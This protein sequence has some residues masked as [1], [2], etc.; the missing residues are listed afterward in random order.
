[1]L[2][3]IHNVDIR[4]LQIF[5]TIVQCNGFSAAQAQLNMSQSAISTCMSSLETRLGFRLC[6]RGKK[7]FS[8]TAEGEQVLC[9][10]QQLFAKLDA[11]VLQVH[12]LSGRLRGELLIG[13]LDST[14]TLPEAKIVEAIRRFYQRNHEVSLQVFIKSPTELEQEIISGELHAAI[15]YIGH[16]LENLE[17]ID[18]FSEKISIYCGRHHPLYLSSKVTSGDL[19]RFSW[20]KR[21]YL[22]PSDLVPVTPSLITA[23]AHQ[24]EAV[25]LLILAGTHM[26]YLPQ[27][28]AQQWVDK[29]EMYQLEP[30]ELSYEVTHCLILNRNRPHN[31]ALEALVSDI[32]MEHGYPGP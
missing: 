13:L 5:L 27:H 30:D 7:G 16:R 18:L 3:N 25:A 9:Y 15:S 29:Q 22:M 32:R 8:L 4:L 11:F 19:Q 26:G 1:M 12:N 6:E 23:T 21:G 2:G 31:E 14:L 17:Y 28:Y 20:V 10:T 24:M